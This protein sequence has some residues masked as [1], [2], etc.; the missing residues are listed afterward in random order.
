MMDLIDGELE[1][2]GYGLWALETRRDGALIGFAGLEPIGFLAHFTP[3]IEVGWR[4]AR[5]AWGHGYATEAGAAAIEYG[6]AN[7]GLRNIVSIT[8]TT[9]TRSI[10]VME[11]LGMRRDPAED[12]DHPRLPREHRLCR[13]VLYRIDADGWRV[14]RGSGPRP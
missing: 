7:G 14:S 4:L 10:A 9:N 3:A 8:S 12:F 13:H 1:Q 11:R 2:R 6:F 5:R